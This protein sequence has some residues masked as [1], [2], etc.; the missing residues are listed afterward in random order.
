[1]PQGSVLGPLLYLIYVNDIV[2]LSPNLLPILF[3]DDTNVFMSGDNIAET[4]G[5]MN[6]AIDKS[7]DWTIVNKLSLNIDR[8]HYIIFTSR[9]R[10]V[11]TN[12]SVLLNT[13]PLNKVEDTKFRGVVID[14]KLTWSDHIKHIKRS[15]LKE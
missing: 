15:Y 13:T 8:T 14:S 2:N 10:K 11:R 12:L 1:M 6:E 7:L 5:L 9:G 3:A 4:I